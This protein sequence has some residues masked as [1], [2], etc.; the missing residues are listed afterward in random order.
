[1]RRSIFKILVM[2]SKQQHLFRPNKLFL[3][4]FHFPTFII[5]IFVLIANKTDIEN[6]D[7]EKNGKSISSLCIPQTILERHW[8]PI[9]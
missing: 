8:C 1:M 3:F 7:A 4:L 6:N 5:L 9:S 2:V